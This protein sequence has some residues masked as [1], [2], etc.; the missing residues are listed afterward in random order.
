MRLNDKIRGAVVGFA[1]GDALGLGAEFMTRNEVRAYYPEGLRHFS[2]IIRDAHRCQW[3]RGEWTNDTELVTRMLECVLEEGGFHMHKMARKLKEWYDETPRDIAPVLRLLCSDPEWLEHPV[4][5]AHRIWKTENLHEASNEAVQR[6]LVTGLVSRTSELDENTRRLVLMTNDDTRCV[7]TTLILARMIHRLLHDER[8]EEYDD[9]AELCQNID[10]RTL[11]FLRMARDGEIDRI[12]VDDEA[13][14]AWTRKA[15]ASALWGLWHSNNA[16]DTIYNVI[17]EGGDAD[18]NAAIAGALAGLKYG[19][20]ALPDEKE[21][22]IGFEY[23]L[24]LSD[25]LTE[26]LEKNGIYTC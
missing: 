16:A 10:P 1:F 21:K 6:C 25:R 9:L 22:L 20:D 12:D 19:Y 5:T 8:E 13:T 23:L 4:Q 14:Q 15:M 17:A 24:D 7:S 11:S 3:K 18:S 26:Y 2:Q